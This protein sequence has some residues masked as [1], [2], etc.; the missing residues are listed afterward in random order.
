[1]AR[2]GA[3][4]FGSI[5]FWG[6]PPLL[7]Q[8]HPTSASEEDL[9]GVEHKNQSA[10]VNSSDN[11][12]TIPRRTQHT[13]LP[14]ETRDSKK[15]KKI[16]GKRNKRRHVFFVLEDRL[17]LE[18]HT[19][20]QTLEKEEEEKEG[21]L[22]APEPASEIEQPARPAENGCCFSFFSVCVCCL[23]SS[24]LRGYLGPAKKKRRPAAASTI[25][26]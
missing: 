16:I 22:L 14:R 9:S 24:T 17:E 25:D 10:V 3:G 21:S 13:T 20:T 6:A 7:P 1:M 18:T 8:C 2:A 4:R 12:K 15:K 26:R 11:F 5:S 19:H 23:A